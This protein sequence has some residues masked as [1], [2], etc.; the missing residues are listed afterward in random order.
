MSQYC[1]IFCTVPQGDTGRKIAGE[2]INKQLAACVNTVPGIQSC[3]SWKGKVCNDSESLLI[4][5]T[6]TALTETVIS[7]IRSI[8]PYDVPEIIAVDIMNG[9]AEYLAWIGESTVQ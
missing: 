4:I 6:R 9:L 1:I 8:H 3:Y 2:L 7:E 5:K